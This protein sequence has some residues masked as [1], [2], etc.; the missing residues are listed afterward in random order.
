MN[1]RRFFTFLLC[2]TIIVFSV[3]NNNAVSTID[4][5]AYVVAIG[6][7]S[8]PNG[9]IN[10]SLQIAIP[11]SNGS[12]SSPSSS[13]Q[14]SS[15][16]VNTVE[17]DTVFSGITLINSYIS[18]KLNLS[19]CKVVVFSEELASKGISNYISTFIN[20]I[21][22]RPT[23]HVLISRCEAKYF[24]E[25]SKPMLENISSKYYEIETASEKNTGYTKAVTLLDFYNSY[26]DTFSQP[27][28][29]L[30]SINGAYAGDIE[31]NQ[32]S[33][34]TSPQSLENLNE[35]S[36]VESES[37]NKTQ[38]NIENL[39][40]AVFN[41]DS[42]VGELTSMQTIYHLILSNQLK[43]TII[44]IPSPLSD[45]DYIS[46]NIIN[47]KTKNTVKII[48]NTPYISCD[49]NLKTR[50]ISSSISANYLTNENIE[51]LQ[52]Y[53]NSYIKS[54]IQEYLYKTSVEF[55][56]DIV[57][58]G[59]YAVHNFKTIEEW[60][61]YNWLSNYRNSFFSV[62]VNTSIISSYL[63]LGNTQ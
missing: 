45:I 46:L 25:N 39:G 59:K 20:D 21:E 27:Y 24:L 62:N 28:T 15:T 30:G 38:H 5:S 2:L 26:Y 17:C 40:L 60:K 6:L 47:A 63:V 61:N 48:N 3:T 42:F 44:N 37:S 54:H 35:F 55:K 13:E 18:K 11:S 23:C 51:L 4:D 36:S 50:V 32:F 10:L 1:S 34:G 53:A 16:I 19:Y 7:D 22:V 9:K 29:I 52:E 12:S 56:S 49:V 31:N 8:S 33:V 41:G 57:G 43:G 58:F 14:S